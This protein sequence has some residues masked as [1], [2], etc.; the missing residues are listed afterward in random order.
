MNI[1]QNCKGL[2]FCIQMQ[3]VIIVTIKKRGTRMTGSKTARYRPV[4]Q[5]T[6][7]PRKN[8]L[9]PGFSLEKLTIKA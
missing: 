3:I 5:Q 4:S 9:I 8:N 6:S 7:V 1:A 2:P